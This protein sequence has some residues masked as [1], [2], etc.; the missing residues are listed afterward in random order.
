MAL[1]R[2]H[3]PSFA[4]WCGP[5]CF[6]VT[7]HPL[8]YEAVLTSRRFNDK[9]SW[10]PMLRAALGRGLIV[11]SGEPW[12]RHRKAVAPSLHQRVL[13]QNVQVFHRKARDVSDELLGP[14]AATGAPLDIKGFCDLVSMDAVCET[15]LSADLS[16][17]RDALKSF[18]DAKNDSCALVAR[19]VCRPWLLLDLVYALTA[20]E[21]EA[22]RIE[23]LTD[24]FVDEVIRRKRAERRD[25]GHADRQRSFLQH[26]LADSA[27]AS[28]LSDEELREEAK[29]MVIAGEGTVANALSFTLLMLAMHPDVQQAVQ[30]ELQD[31]FGEDPGRGVTEHDLPH[32]ELLERVVLETLRLFPLV[33]VFLRHVAEDTAL[34]NFHMHRDPAWYPDPLR[35]DPDRFLPDQVRG[36]P[37]LSFAA[38]SAGPRSCIGQRYAIMYLKTV[39]STVLRRYEVH[40]APG[41]TRT[42]ADLPVEIGVIL[43]LDGGFP[44]TVSRRRETATTRSAESDAH[45]ETINK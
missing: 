44:V 6:V 45:L 12:R 26:V 14:A 8:D 25:E 11:L 38:F 9:S 41:D 40:R 36:R 33:A 20:E 1:V 17:D 39:L 16:D 18:V 13:A 4:F 7:A 2:R 35:F 29:A 15:I 37:P 3:A 23:A 27:A 32:L 10:Y 22:R 19:R 24:R 21:R 43:S 31:V 42:V 30:Q 34:P 5:A 28:L